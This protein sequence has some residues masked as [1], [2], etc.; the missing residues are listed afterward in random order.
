MTGGVLVVGSAGVGA[1]EE[2]S[3]YV[4]GVEEYHGGQSLENPSRWLT[5]RI[6][7]CA[8]DHKSTSPKPHPTLI[9]KKPSTRMGSSSESQLFAD[10]TQRTKAH[11]S[12]RISNG[13]LRAGYPRAQ[14]SQ[15]ASRA[16]D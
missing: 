6:D 12:V 4:W 9:P 14:E 3:G 7:P 13:E 5:K 11:Y 1:P 2:V 10:N 15:K 8:R 16:V